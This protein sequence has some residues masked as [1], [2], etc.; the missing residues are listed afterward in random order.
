[1]VPQFHF[2]FYILIYLIMKAFIFPVTGFVNYSGY[3]L[4]LC[5]E[6]DVRK[7]NNL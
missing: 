4:I 6:Q 1:M 3:V 7:N 2:Y 5:F